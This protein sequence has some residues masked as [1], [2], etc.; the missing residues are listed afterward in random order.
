MSH[1]PRFSERRRSSRGWP[2]AALLAP[3]LGS[4]LAGGCKQSSPKKQ[5]AALEWK[6]LRLGQPPSQ[7][8]ARAKSLGWVLTC[9]PATTVLYL[10]G[11]E[12]ATQ[13]VLSAEQKR[14]VRCVGQRPRPTGMKPAKPGD[15]PRLIRTVLFFL[16][17]RLVRMNILVATA[18]PPFAKRMHANWGRF[19]HR[20]LSIRLYGAKKRGRIRA[21]VKRVG[22]TALIWLRKA[23]AQELIFVTTDPKQVKALKH[24]ATEKKG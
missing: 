20:D 7:A 14:T 18:D 1:H 8:R 21:Q 10:D 16:D 17:G 19:D 13:W 3:L 2:R 4:L 23:R 11:D 6:G 15:S 24:I 22:H 9:K 12:L 5:S